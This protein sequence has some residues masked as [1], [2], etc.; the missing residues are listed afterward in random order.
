MQKIGLPHKRAQVRIKVVV[1]RHHRF[2]AELFV[3]PKP[4][5]KNHDNLAKCKIALHKLVNYG[6]ACKG[7]NRMDGLREFL[8]ESL[9]V[10]GVTR[11]PLNPEIEAAERFLA[12]PVPAVADMMTL[13]LAFHRDAELRNRRGMN[14]P[15]T[16]GSVP[17]TG[18]PA[19]AKR[20]AEILAG[21]PKNQPYNTHVAYMTLRPFMT[22]NGVSGRILWLWGWRQLAQPIPGSFLRQWYRTTLDVGAIYRGAKK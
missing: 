15:M 16:M 17:P 14:L 7:R 21:A 11:A 9:R 13:A 8:D 6:Y 22:G 2:G 4:L 3:T 19:V 10:E 12:L 1:S 5:V 20:L 18:G